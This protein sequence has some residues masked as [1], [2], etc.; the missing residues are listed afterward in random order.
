MSSCLF[1]F[2]FLVYMFVLCV[3]CVLKKG[4]PFCWRLGVYRTE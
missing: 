3:L 2:F 4:L 1:L